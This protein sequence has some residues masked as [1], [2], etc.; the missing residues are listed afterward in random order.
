MSGSGKTAILNEL[1]TGLFDLNPNENFAVLSFNFEMLARRLVGRKISKKLNKSVKQLY[2]AD[3]EDPQYN[4]TEEDYKAAED[5]C[6]NELSQYPLYY[7]DVSGTVDDIVKTIEDFALR[8]ENK[9]RGVVVTIDHSILVKKLKGQKQLDVLY[10]L[11][12]KLNDLKKKL[13]LTFVVLSQLNRSIEAVDRIENADLQYPQKADVFG[14]DALYQFSD[15]F[16]IT[17]RPEMLNI[18]QY[19]PNKLPTEGYVY[20]HFLKTRDGDPF[21][22]QM[23]N[24]LKHNKI[25]EGEFAI[26]GT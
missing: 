17:H 19:G 7:V 13:K 15:M 20:W 4:L 3:L 8:E 16:M 11:G 10:E 26:T 21:V 5:Y 24:D 12:I 1:E 14:A 2:S 23:I 25:V 9:A 6:K 22:G 18:R